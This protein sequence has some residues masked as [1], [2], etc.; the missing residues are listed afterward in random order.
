MR[1]RSEQRQRKARDRPEQRE[2]ISAAIVR[3]QPAVARVAQ[4][5]GRQR[6]VKAPFTD[7]ATYYARS[8]FRNATVRSHARR[9][10]A[11]S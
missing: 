10:A 6:F 3:E 2:L 11:G 9:A 8:R 7:Q 4:Q 1:A 5:C